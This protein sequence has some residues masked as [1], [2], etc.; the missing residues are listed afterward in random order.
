M[1]PD[2]TPGD[3][4][5]GDG[6]WL[7]HLADPARMSEVF[8]R[9]A[10]TLELPVPSAT[11]ELLDARLTHPHRPES[12]RCR[13]WATY[14][15][16]PRDGEPV[17][18]YVKGFPTGAASRDA[19]ERDRAARPG[20]RSTHLPELH[21]V[22]WR[23]PEDPQLAVLPELIGFGPAANIVPP[24]VREVMEMAAGDVVRTTVVRYQP[25]TSATL[26]IEVNRAGAPAVF[27]KHLADGSVPEIAARHQALWSRAD[28]VG[29]LRLAEP[30]AADPGRGVLWTRG[31]LGKALAASVT[32]DEL[33]TATAPIGRLLA[34]LHTSPAGA[35]PSLTVDDLL[36][37]AGKKATKLIRA[38]PPVGPQVTGLVATATRR[39]RDAGGP[40]QRC[41][42]HG[43]FHLDQLVS[44][45]QGPV[46]VDLDSVVQGPPEVDVAEFLVDL[47]LRN[48][49]GA[50]V[51]DVAQGLLS[52]YAVARGAPVDPALLEVCADAEFLNRC[53]RHLR[54]HAPGWPSALEAE[55]DRHADVTA[56]LR[57]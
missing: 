55:L 9:H 15:L 16:V 27:A 22:V 25:E 4:D 53:Y 26:R 14:L 34:A 1:A 2:E 13:G 5:G 56:L 24:V 37:E 11:V 33:S 46:L 12:P 40:A 44:S 35:T 42:L 30:L 38:H 57:G 28:P 20:G 36:A 41:T 7:P 23:F 31:V 39:R 21:L 17:Q 48:L 6:V 10:D 32:T 29:G 54:R 52:S 3:E 43:D 19:W 51:R 8:S 47:A 49:P 45:A 50:V 18:L